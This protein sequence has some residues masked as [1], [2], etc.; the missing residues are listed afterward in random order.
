MSC[1]FQLDLLGQNLFMTARNMIIM[2]KG[3]VVIDL[4]GDDTSFGIET[5]AETHGLNSFFGI[6]I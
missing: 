3:E 5:C 2:R 6:A 4:V 1:E